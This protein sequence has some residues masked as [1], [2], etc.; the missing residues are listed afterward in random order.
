MYVYILLNQLFDKNVKNRVLVLF[1]LIEL[2]QTDINTGGLC[3]VLHSVYR[4]IYH[5]LNTVLQP[6]MYIDK[7]L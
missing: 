6:Y 3:T 7:G 1:Y 2:P 5:V 4:Y